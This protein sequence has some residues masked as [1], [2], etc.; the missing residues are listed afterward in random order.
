MDRPHDG[1]QE[2]DG[3]GLLHAV[4]RLG[5]R[6][7]GD[8]G[9]AQ[10]ARLRA[11]PL[12]QHASRA[13]R[14]CPAPFPTACS[15]SRPRPSCA[16]ISAT[17]SRSRPTR[18]STRS[19]RA[20]SR[21][22]ARRPNSWRRASTRRWSTRSCAWSTAPSTSGDRCRPACA[23]RRRPS[24]RTGAC[25]SRT[26]T[27]PRPSR[28]RGGGRCLRRTSPRDGGGP[29][30]S[31]PALVGAYCWVENRIFE[32]SGA[33]ATGTHD[34]PCGRAR[35]S[36]AGL[37]RRRVPAPR[38]AGRPAGP[39]GSRCGPASTGRALVA[40][41][42]R[43]V[44]RGA[45]RAG[46]MPNARAGVAAWSRRVLPRLQAVYGVHRQTAN[47]VSEASV[48]EVLAGAHRVWPPRSAVA[49]ALLEGSA[50][51]ADEGCRARAPDRTGV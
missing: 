51:G 18:S 12:S 14:V 30:T 27:A 41:A 25:P 49:R 23:S 45:R 21:A 38:T 42:G 5:R 7:R 15:T 26:A 47:P 31:W 10:D 39:S 28:S 43:A 33:W 37:V 50:D 44:G 29:S 19:S 1:Q 46:R 8:Q 11:V 9:R 3:D 48:L 24:A 22:T 2:R 36:A 6:L 13:R 35:A 20:T 32:L 17:T 4:R 34:G 40:A 16:R